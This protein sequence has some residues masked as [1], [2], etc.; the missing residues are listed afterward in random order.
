MREW[1]NDFIY[2]F[3]YYFGDRRGKTKHV[4][5]KASTF[6]AWIIRKITQKLKENTTTTR[7]TI[8]NEENLQIR[9]KKKVMNFLIK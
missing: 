2:L 4:R 5:E 6:A 8:I 3:I 9:K 7:N 1:K